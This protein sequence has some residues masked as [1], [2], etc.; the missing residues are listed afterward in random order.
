VTVR[1]V[2]RWERQAGLPVYRQGGSRKARVYAYSDELQKWLEQ[3]GMALREAGD[4]APPDRRRSWLVVTAGALAA[5]AAAALVLW[6]TGIWPAR[7]PHSWRFAGGHLLIEDVH[8][9]LCW[10]KHLLPFD[11]SFE[12]DTQDKVLI[13]DIDGDGR[14]QVV[15][16]YVPADVAEKG[17]SVMCF[18][19]R[20][21]LRWQYQYGASK[22]FGSR[23]FAATYRGN[24]L[25]AVRAHGVPLLLTVANHYIWY[26][27]QVALLDPRTGRLLQEYWHPGAIYDCLLHDLDHDGQDEVLLGAINN[28]GEGLG[29]AAL[30]VLKLPFSDAPRHTAPAGDPLPPATGGGELA[31][32]LFPL[33]DTS[34]AA[35]LL[36]RMARL[37]VDAH[38]RILVETVAPESSAIVY[39]LDLNLNVVE[40]RLSD[41]FAAVLERYYRQHLLDHHF[42]AAEVALLG[43]VV[44][45]PAAPDGNSPSCRG[46]GPSEPDKPAEPHCGRASALTG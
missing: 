38:E 21:S 4:A 35:G 37:A 29:H 14:A 34:R 9:R 43:K 33:P 30:A 12:S 24:L 18:N 45:L 7:V 42:S 41:N 5:V 3:G 19:H 20:G 28:P 23:T 8:H 22:T 15:V 17:G 1:S 36:P 13:A 25:R 11:P 39:Y 16:N 26:P 32:R 6:Q 10:E 27:S 40:F 2:E 44:A 46:S 31:Y